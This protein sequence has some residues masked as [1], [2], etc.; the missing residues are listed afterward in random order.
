MS[1][2]ILCDTQEQ[3]DHYWPARRRRRRTIRAMRLA[4]GSLR[5]LVAGGSPRPRPTRGRPRSGASRTRVRRDDEDGQDRSCADRAGGERRVKPH[6]PV[7]GGSPV[8][9]RNSGSLM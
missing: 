4:Q 1:L 7:G 2:Q 3:I 6:S 8:R 9:M 5:R